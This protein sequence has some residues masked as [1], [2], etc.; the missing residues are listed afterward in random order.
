MV[1]K[2]NSVLVT[3]ATGLVGRQ[4]CKELLKRGYSVHVLS[5]SN[6]K[7]E[8]CTCFL[9]DI[10]AQEIDPKAFEGVSAIIHL[11]G[12][13]VGDRRWTTRY[14]QQIYDSRI[15]STRLLI[16]TLKTLD[17]KVDSLI[18]ASAVGYYD[19]NGSEWINEEAPMAEE[20]IARLCR[21]WESEGQGAETLDIRYVALRIG[22]VLSRKGGFLPKTTMTLPLRMLNYFGNGQH[23]YAWIHEKDVVDMFCHALT[24]SSV[25]GVYNAV[26]PNPIPQKMMLAELKKV[27]SKAL[28]VLPVPTFALRIVL[29]EMARVVV[30][31]QRVSAQKI[32][33]TGYTY[34]FDKVDE[35]FSDLYSV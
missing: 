28:I 8:G 25:R 2:G 18:S 33:D 17:H 13:G 14:K 4:L 23:Y 29:G 3:G 9:W 34:S 24:N 16:N 1:S 35:A 15:E 11:A 7:M 6:R 22:L 27:L 20:F 5:R 12:A 30:F 26:A 21:D 31:S 19:D 32:Q 10:E